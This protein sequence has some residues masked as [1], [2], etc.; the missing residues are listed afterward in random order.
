MILLFNNYILEN[1][2]YLYNKKLVTDKFN[3]KENHKIQS[4]TLEITYLQCKFKN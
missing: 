3:T 1:D 4:Y 2:F